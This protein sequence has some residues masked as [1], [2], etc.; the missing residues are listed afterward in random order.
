LSINNEN[1][2]KNELVSD[3]IQNAEN[4]I[5]PTAPS[6][7]PQQKDILTLRKHN[8][9]YFTRDGVILRT[10]YDNIA[11][12]YLLCL[13][14]LWDNAADFLTKHYKGAD[15][16]QIITKIH[17]D[18]Y[19]FRIVVKNSNYKDIEVFQDKDTIFNYEGRSGTKQGVYV[20]SRGLL[21]DAMKQL[22][23]LGYVLVN[24]NDDGTQLTNK[25]WDYPLTIRHN[26]EEWKVKLFVDKIQ[27]SGFVVPECV[28]RDLN[29][30]DTEIELTLP[31]VREARNLT[32]S[33]IEVFCKEYATLTTDITLKFRILDE[34]TQPPVS[35]VA[36]ESSLDDETIVTS[37]Y[38][39]E[40]DEEPTD[41]EIENSIAANI[42][43]ALTTSADKA[44]VHLEFPALHPLSL[45]SLNNANSVHTCSP[46]EFAD[47]II[48]AQ[49]KDEITIH[50]FL[51]T[52]RE[53]TQIAKTVDNQKSLLQLVNNPDRDRKILEYYDQLKS[54][55][56]PAKEI[57]LPY[58]RKE[59]EAALVKRISKLYDIDKEQKPVYKLISGFFD[60]T[61]LRK[62][63]LD[64]DTYRMETG[65]GIIKYPYV[66][67]IIAI[68]RAKPLEG[69]QKGKSKQTIFIGAV[70]YSTSPKSNIFEGEYG[71]LA[72]EARSI[73][74]VLEK[75]NFHRYYGPISK[76]PCIIVGNLIT[77]RLEPHGYDKSRIDIQPFSDTI[78]KA[79]IKVAGGIKTYRAAGYHFTKATNYSTARLQKTRDKETLEDYLIQLLRRDRGLRH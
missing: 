7:N 44:I 45:E 28:S 65:K 27:Q 13:K 15:D 78:I 20:I 62:V 68:P 38:D 51:Q 63:W 19:L 53:G 76:L 21:G 22:L 32:R 50:Q 43:S 11:Y 6:P 41:E 26:G 48:N 35:K 3:P 60:D 49:H 40:E 9:D 55:L 1:N 34:S 39:G 66:F 74:A 36:S 54:A 29:H 75:C 17:K 46:S 73:I 79:C 4:I 72:S 67:E 70:N 14:E 25:Q 23:S 42:I 18:D 69:E 2:A 5:P 61:T 56:P 64:K 8:M 57:T 58:K 30:T 77:L 10:G 16:T 12:W 59:R 31:I 47:R 52:Y 71:F 24:L 33:R 37:D